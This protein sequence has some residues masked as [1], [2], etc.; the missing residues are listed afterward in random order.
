MLGD[1]SATPFIGTTNPAAARAFYEGVLGLHL[2]AD[3]SFA[4]IFRTG[5]GR[6]NVSKTD[7]VS[8]APY[9][10]LGWTVRDIDSAV[11]AL[12]A[13]GV[14]FVRFDCFPQDAR[15]IMAFPDGARVAW[16]RDPDGN[17]L[18]LTQ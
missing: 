13:R 3:E 1:A 10:V 12:A 14:A 9:T 5:N 17:L 16:F 11:D 18:S 2:I 6:L 15:G 8:P 7:A 4:M